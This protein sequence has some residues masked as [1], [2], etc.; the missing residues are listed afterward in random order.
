MT[1][2]VSTLFPAS[3]PSTSIRLT[4]AEVISW[5]AP[6][7]PLAS[8]DPTGLSSESTSKD[9]VAKSPKY[10]MQEDDADNP[11]VLFFYEQFDSYKLI[12]I[13]PLIDYIFQGKLLRS[14]PRSGPCSFVLHEK[15]IA[16]AVTDIRRS[17]LP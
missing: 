6:T 15:I 17:L 11:V 9:I 3:C 2:P 14:G 12:E 16:D 8:S 5:T 10:V 7:T 13:S 4:L 1:S